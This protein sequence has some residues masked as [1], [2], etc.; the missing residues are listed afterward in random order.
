EITHETLLRVWPRLAGWLDD[1]RA[2][3]RVHRRL[4]EAAHTWDEH[5]RDEGCLYRGTQLS[6]AV[7]WAE[8]SDHQADLNPLERTFLDESVALR[9]RE[10]E[11]EHAR[12]RHLEKL[13]A[14]AQQQTKPA[15]SRRLVL[16]A[17]RPRSVEPRHSLL[18]NL[19]AYRIAPTTEARNG[20]VST[21]A[22]QYYAG[23][24]LGHQVR[25]TA[26]TVS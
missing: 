20:L 22:H 13:A 12:A 16:E 23:E 3:L 9:S 7:E 6:H 26:L 25:I 18:L 19:A 11:A 17:E 5:G 21:A 15:I 10:Q 4:T 8:E 24:F 2:G 1:D 14:D